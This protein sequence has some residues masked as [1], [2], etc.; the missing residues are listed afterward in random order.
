MIRSA[1]RGRIVDDM[2]VSEHLEQT[3]FAYDSEFPPDCAEGKPLSS[4]KSAKP[5]PT[6]KR[7]L[8]RLVSRKR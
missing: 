8:K 2:T 7:A 1:R 6:V 5:A 4:V 3:G